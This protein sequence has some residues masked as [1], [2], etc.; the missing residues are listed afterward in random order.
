MATPDSYTKLL[1]HSNNDN[2]STTFTDSSSYGHV[3]TPYTGGNIHHSTDYSV[4][5]KSSIR[6][7]GG[8]S[9]YLYSSD[10]E[11]LHLASSFAIDF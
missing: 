5:G 11:Y 3:F 8:H 2:N 4:F 6:F 7:H 1:I 9:D 10:S